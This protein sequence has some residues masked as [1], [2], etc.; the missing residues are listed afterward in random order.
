MSES[1]IQLLDCTLRDGSYIVDGKFGRKSIGGIIKRLQDSGVEIIECGWL[2]DTGHE[3]GSAFYRTPSDMEQ[4]FISP[5][6]PGVIYVAMIDYNRYDLSQLPDYDGKSVDAIR[7]V[8]PKDKVD[9]GLSLVEPIRNKGYKVFLQAAN[10]PGYSDE[11][12]LNLV[13]MVNNAKPECISIVDTFGTMYPEDLLH[14][15][16]IF[17]HNLDKDI[18]LGLHSHNNQQLSF[19]NA[20]EFVKM[21]SGKG[22][23]MVV[24]SSLCGMGRGAGNACTELVTG[25]LNHKFGKLYDLD[26]IMDTIDIYMS[27]F[28]K[29]YEWGYSIPYF[30]SGMYSAHVNNIAYLIKTHKTRARDLKNVIESLEPSKRIVYDYDNLERVYVEF[31]S[32]EVNDEDTLDYLKSQLVG[33]DIVLIVPGKSAT[34]E[35]ETVQRRINGDTVV[36][37][38][39]AAI[40]GYKYDY[41]FFSNT[42]RYDYAIEQGLINPNTQVIL[43]SNIKQCSD[44]EYIVNYNKLI[45]RGWKLFE[46]SIMMLL[47]LLHNLGVNKLSVAGWDGFEV[48]GN[49]YSDTNMEPNISSDE[50]A[51]FNKDLGEM[52]DDF[53]QRGG[54]RIDFITPSRFNMEEYK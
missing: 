47:K 13:K 2:K 33:K 28:L 54:V 37:G 18:K 36:I 23:S 41:L 34:N 50:I 10:T 43:T 9:E 3:I 5:K 44:N 27:Q 53:R 12:L 32:N 52:L 45:S 6:R 4:Y 29:Q 35:F 39:N 46:V 11:E 22:R 25:Y 31:Q 26:T 14:I 7:V 40:S 24:D 51:C 8:F 38:V 49:N 17:D 15:L 48:S 16:E 42:V 1:S 20:M 30:I 21:L 19:A